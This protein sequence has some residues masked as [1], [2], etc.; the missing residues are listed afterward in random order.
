MHRA[1]PTIARGILEV[2]NITFPSRSIQPTSGLVEG[3]K[4]PHGTITGPHGKAIHGALKR[5]RFCP[6]HQGRGTSYILQPLARPTPFTASP[7][8]LAQTPRTPIL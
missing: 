2:V 1:T 6:A 3:H 4:P 7:L 8:S 5:I